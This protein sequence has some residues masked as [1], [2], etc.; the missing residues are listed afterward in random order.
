MAHFVKMKALKSSSEK[1]SFRGKKK[2]K[3]HKKALFGFKSRRPG[4][5][6]KGLTLARLSR[7]DFRISGLLVALCLDRSGSSRAVQPQLLLIPQGFSCGQSDPNFGRL[8]FLLVDL[9]S[10]FVASS[11]SSLLVW[12]NPVSLF[13]S[14]SSSGLKRERSSFQSSCYLQGFCTADS[15]S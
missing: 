7:S 9:V 14:N 6:F 3:T 15:P 13:L 5:G 10:H 1:E 11:S 4:F 12:V 2:R 8:N